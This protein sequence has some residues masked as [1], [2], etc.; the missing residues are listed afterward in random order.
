[1]LEVRPT[2]RTG[3]DSGV[4]PVRASDSFASTEEKH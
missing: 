1:M 4:L 2:E 3:V